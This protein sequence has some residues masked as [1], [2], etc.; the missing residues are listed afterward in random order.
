ME[1]R[2]SRTPFARSLV[3]SACLIFGFSSIAFFLEA[4]GAPGEPIAPSPP[5]AVAI[6]DLSVRQSGD[7]AQ[8]TFTLP[9][10]TIHGDHLPETPAL[11]IVRGILKPD[12]SP[13]AKSFHVVQTIPGS[14]V[15]KYLSDGHAQII[16]PI[17]ADETRIHPGAAVAYR[18]RT[19]VS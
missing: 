1:N 14:L 4:C 10:K 15:S 19:R 8:L 13:D 17:S 3:R 16:D 2:N 7:G 9:V 11:E 18:V 5:V 12:G 6:T